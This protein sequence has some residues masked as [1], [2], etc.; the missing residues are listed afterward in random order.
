MQVPIFVISLADAASRRAQIE[1]QMQRYGLAFEF[2]DAVNGGA[3]TDEQ[4]VLIDKNWQ[5]RRSGE[6]MRPS[7]IGCAMS[8]ALLW[9]RLYEEG[10]ISAIVL[11]DDAVLTEDFVDVALNKIA[12]PEE[13]QLIVFHCYANQFGERKSFTAI[14]EKHR[15]YRPFRRFFGTC[16]YYLTNEAAHRLYT[17][18][19]PIWTQADWPLVIQDELNARGIEPA[20]VLHD[21][22]FP[23]TI[24]LFNRRIPIAVR[25]G[26]LLLVPTLLFPGT[27]GS[28]WK[29]RYAWGAIFF[30]CS[31]VLFARRPRPVKAS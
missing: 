30:K 15:L 7:E 22:Q 26:R 16:G 25:I 3:L 11:E 24:Q 1:A 23:S 20:I 18:A 17:A 4:E 8:H 13:H 6:A 12:F 31:A 14:N 28:Y 10:H 5:A 9:K 27:F 19:L 2:V 29:A 21:E